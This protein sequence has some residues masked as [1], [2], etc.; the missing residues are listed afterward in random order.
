MLG[1]GVRAGLEYL[2]IK[3]RTICHI[4]REAHAASVLAARMEEGSL[5][6]APIWS[7]VTTFPARSFSGKVDGI[8]AG[9]PCQD[10]SIAGKQAGLDGE[11]SGLFFA[12]PPIADACGAQ[13]MFLENVAAISSA[14]ATVVDEASASDYAPKPFG[15]VFSD[16]GVE[17]GRLFERAASRVL[18]ELADSGW[19][20]EWITISAS[21]VGAS[22]GRARWFCFAWR[23]Q[24][25][26][27]G[28]QYR[29]IQQREIRPQHTGA[30][31]GL[32]DASSIGRQAGS[33]LIGTE[34][35]MGAAWECEFGTGDRCGTLADPNGAGLQGREF[36]RRFDKAGGG[37]SR[38]DQLAN[39]AVYSPLVQAT[40]DGQESSNDSPKSPRHLKGA[41]IQCLESGSWDG[42]SV[43]PTQNLKWGT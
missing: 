37:V 1:E 33:R 32:A 9:F 6:Q 15:E 10:I 34:K 14:S 20:A 16:V 4:E 21:D 5:D 13:W 31:S 23:R 39:A 2:G 26:N 12:I 28:L 41:L 11:R 7:D 29:D 18:G 22:H 40:S 17:D 30:S 24:V 19:D 36:N 25:G 38:M 8:I 3:H 27:T 42:P 43:G 35:T